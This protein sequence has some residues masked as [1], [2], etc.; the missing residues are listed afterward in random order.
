MTTARMPPENK[1]DIKINVG[2]IG[3]HLVNCFWKNPPPTSPQKIKTPI[4]RTNKNNAFKETVVSV[5]V[6]LGLNDYLK[7]IISQIKQ[8]KHKTVP[9]FI[10]GGCLMLT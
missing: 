7:N 1:K 9:I 2:M 3:N 5:S 6:C 4:C 10:G 8:K